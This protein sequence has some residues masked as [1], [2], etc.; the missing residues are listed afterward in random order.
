MYSL[1]LNPN[2]QAASEVRNCYSLIVLLKCTY[3]HMTLMAAFAI[4]VLADSFLDQSA[5]L[6]FLSYYTRSNLI[7]I[8]KWHLR[9]ADAV[10][11]SLI[12]LL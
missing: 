8:R 3:I 10:P 2:P 12:V 5:L 11:L 4:T 9:Y 1:K 6:V 7:P